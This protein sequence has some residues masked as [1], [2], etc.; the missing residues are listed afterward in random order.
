MGKPPI[1]HL[2]R[3]LSHVVVV[4]GT[5]MLLIASTT[6]AAAAGSSARSGWS[7]YP[8]PHG[9]PTANTAP[10]PQRIVPYYC[11]AHILVPSGTYNPSNGYLSA[12]VEGYAYCN[13]NTSILISTLVFAGHTGSQNIW[14][15]GTTA[16]CSNCR[17]AA[18]VVAYY[19]AFAP[20]GVTTY[21]HWGEMEISYVLPSGTHISNTIYGPSNSGVVW[22]SC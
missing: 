17:Q 5:L 20:C 14:N 12:W 10:V 4:T 16:S 2:T 1:H 15:I 8:A 6:Y 13:F 11:S 18:W 7:G 21:D 22:N 9:V 3:G 19:G